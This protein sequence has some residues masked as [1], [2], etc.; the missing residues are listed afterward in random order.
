MTAPQN[1]MRDTVLIGG[2]W[3][4]RSTTTDVENPATGEIVGRAASAT[5]ADVNL[6][7]AAAVAAGVGWGR[8]T[9]KQ[10]SA[11]LEELVTALRDRRDELVAATIA[12]VGA[13]IT[14]AEEAHV[15]L[16]IEIIESFAVIARDTPLRERT[17]NSVLLRRPA[18]VVACITP[19]NY[20][21]YQLAAKVGAALAAGCTTVLK[22]AELTPITTYLFCD[23][24]LETSL[25]AGVVNL[26]PGS[27]TVLGPALTEHPDVAVVSFTG[28]T[29]VGRQVGRSAGELIKRACLELG[30]K[31]ASV[32]LADADFEVAVPATV[33]AAMLN[34]GQTCS[35]WT[36]LLV[37]Q[38]RYDEAVTLAAMRADALVVGD[39]THRSTDLGPLVSHKQRLSVLAA[40]DGA[41]ER[42]A[43]VAAG[44][45]DPIPGLDG[46]YV[47]A[48]VLC[49]IE[50]GDPVT[51]EEIFGPVLVV[52]AYED[53]DDAVTLANATDYGLAGAVWSADAEA[54]L[55]I[56]ARLDTGQVD[57][58]GA[59]FNPLAPFGG[60][61]LS[62]L[63]RELGVIGF[64][65]FTEW[66]SVQM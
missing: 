23:A 44:G 58:N 5:V 16:A 32:L 26:L 57:I 30:G 29:T 34:S 6:A 64:E 20:P 37:P 27:G 19:W 45:S 3:E 1:W 28:S 52:E 8:T 41:I 11:A 59:L 62:G 63:G 9:G 54:A 21:L 53:E 15:D 65:E 50:R 47:R 35:A 48:T 40:V 24:V 49:G 18:G 14:V 17:G 42:G 4:P 43:R 13:P 61:K 25:P 31:S 60:W 36:R 22:P 55:E 7:V 2:R 38:E 51:T 46:H 33:D 10:R 66:T 56:A 12:E 39:P